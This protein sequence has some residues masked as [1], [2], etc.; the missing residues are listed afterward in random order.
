MV[1]Y[2]SGYN[3]AV[4]SG[5]ILVAVLSFSTTAKGELSNPPLLLVVGDVGN[6]NARILFE[7]MYREL[8]QS[9]FVKHST[10]E[11]FLEGEE[12]PVQTHTVEL[13]GKP[14]ILKLY[15]LIPGSN[16]E[17]FFGLMSESVSFCTSSP[18]LKPKLL[19]LSCDRYLDD[20]DDTMWQHL[21][22]KEGNRGWH[23][24]VHMGDQIYADQLATS[25][26]WKGKSHEEIVEMYRVLYRRAWG[27]DTMKPILR[28]GA[29]WMLID[30]HDVMNN[31]N[32]RRAAPTSPTVSLVKAGLQAFMEY[33]YQLHSDLTDLQIPAFSTVDA[34]HDDVL[35]RPRVHQFRKVGQ[36]GVAMLDTRFERSYFHDAD[37]TLLGPVQQEELTLQLRQWQADDSI[38][39]IVVVS[40]V[41]LFLHSQYTGYLADWA[42]GEVYPDHPNLFRQTRALLSSFAAKDSK[43]ELI[44]A[45]DVHLFAN[46][47][48]CTV[49]EKRGPRVCVNQLISSGMTSLSM[50]TSLSHVYLYHLLSTRFT[51][52][53]LDGWRIHFEELFFGRNYARVWMDD[54]TASLQW[55]GVLLPMALSG[56]KHQLLQWFVDWGSVLRTLSIG[57][58]AFV[59]LL[60]MAKLRTETFNEG[61]K[62]Q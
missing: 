31:L 38:S 23:G 1:H 47:R 55:K 30:D 36:L 41:P 44:V 7:P 20:K 62:E 50:S 17:V 58:V 35:L 45:G 57:C 10:V 48:L 54:S 43:V 61:K 37:R 25:S 49:V 5:M 2:L 53:W 11:V 32:T 26:R 59:F 9:E 4:F 27:R 56:F 51:S 12:Q 13:I 29:H 3:M 6:N 46:T 18:L 14:Q 22:Q 42:E 40:S 15:S 19:M 34:S 39:R 28:H 16:Y 60:T 21:L 24:I 52:G 33:Q 8:P